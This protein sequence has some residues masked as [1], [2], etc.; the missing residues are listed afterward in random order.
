MPPAGGPGARLL[1]EYRGYTSQGFTPAQARYLTTPYEGMGHHFIPRR[2]GLPGSIVENPLNIMGNGMSRGSFY[3]RH[4]MGDP[5]FYGTAFP[6]RIG[7]TWSGEAAGLTKPPRPINLWYASPDWLRV[8]AGA[9]A[10]GGGGAAA[11][12]LLNDN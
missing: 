6:K 2:S 10:L 11:W 4:F 12:Y 5:Y 9:G 1:A 8:S 7:G 3:E